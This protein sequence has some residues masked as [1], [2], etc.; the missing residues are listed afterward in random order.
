MSKQTAMNANMTRDEFESYDAAMTSLYGENWHEIPLKRSVF[1]DVADQLGIRKG[2]VYSSL[3][4]ENRAAHGYYTMT[5]ASAASVTTP[6]QQQKISVTPVQQ[7]IVNFPT[8]ET[9]IFSAVSCRADVPEKDREFTKWGHYKDIKQ[10][11]QSNEFFPIYISGFSGTGKTMMIKNVCAELKR[12]FVRVQFTPETSYEDLIGSFRLV[13]GETSWVDGPVIT[14]MKTPGCVLLLD[15]ID[16]SSGSGYLAL[17]GIS[18]GNA[19]LIQKTGELVHPASGFTIIATGNS[20]GRGDESGKYNSAQIIDDAFLERF[21]IDLEQS[22]P[23]KRVLESILTKFVKENDTT[24]FSGADQEQIAKFVD[25]LARWGEMV[26]Q[27]F[28]DEVI[29]EMISVR[30]LVHALKTYGIF[31]NE[32]KA[33]QMTIN[34]FDDVNKEA[35][36]DLFKKIHVL[37]EDSLKQQESADDIDGDDENQSEF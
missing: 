29:D 13:A 4:T 11:I 32:E 1:L 21:V 20:K 17:Q 2:C 10:I 36:M 19:V 12:P 25:S 31:R 16:R 30:R 22:F 18:E 27:S 28:D 24:L 6:A 3:K 26:A 15:E 7:E 14:A 8:R 5:V 35:F 37:P 34:R 23:K 9:P 33:I